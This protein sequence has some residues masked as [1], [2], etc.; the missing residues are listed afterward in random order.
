[1]AK[2]LAGKIFGRLTVT[3]MVPRND[4]PDKRGVPHKSLIFWVCR[5]E[6]GLVIHVRPDRLTE[7]KTR[8]C[9]CLRTDI[10][11]ANAS[12]R[13]ELVAWSAQAKIDIAA[14]RP[15]HPEIPLPPR[16]INQEK[17]HKL[18]AG[19]YDILLKS[20]GGACK[21]CGVVLSAGARLHVDHCHTT[22]AIRGLLCNGCNAGIGFF[23]DDI[24]RM[25]RAIKYLSDSLQT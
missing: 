25:A 16:R 21:I 12:V 13:A 14:G 24:L 20:Q 6:C 11:R 15:T 17:T 23:G 4:V 22:G 3:H 19:G 7:G 2:N 10:R 9:G 18:P 5:C 1:M 8:S